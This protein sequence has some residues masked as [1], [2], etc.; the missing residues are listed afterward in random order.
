MKGLMRRI[1]CLSV[2][3]AAVAAAAWA[4]ELYFSRDFPGSAPAFF[5]VTVQSDGSGGYREALDEEPLEFKVDKATVEELWSRVQALDGL[6]TQLDSK[7]KVAFTGDKVL[8]FTAADGKQAEA[9]FV[10]T[11]DP[12]AQALVAWFL[13]AGE[14]ARHRIELERVIRFDRLGVNDALLRL[15]SAFDRERVIA[16]EQ[17]L[18]VLEQIVNQKNIL[19]LARARAAG[20]IEKIQSASSPVSKE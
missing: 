14:T 11:E 20:L 13:R 12:E 18:P 4:D 2:L 7:R 1:A 16:P 6:A 19:H 15:Q 17:L 5:D 10:Y 8:R 3:L 9:K